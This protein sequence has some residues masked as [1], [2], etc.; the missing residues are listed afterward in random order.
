VCGISVY[1]YTYIC[2]YIFIYMEGERQKCMHRRVSYYS[3]GFV[4]SAQNRDVCVKRE[5]EAEIYV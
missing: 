1:I 4:F 2:M 5:R 3:A